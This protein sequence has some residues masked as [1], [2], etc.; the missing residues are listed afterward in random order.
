MLSVYPYRI[1]GIVS[2]ASHSIFSFV[3]IKAV[4]PC[5]TTSS[6]TFLIPFAFCQVPVGTHYG[7]CI[8]VEYEPVILAYAVRLER[9]TMNFVI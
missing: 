3:Y 8:F 2:T 5:S 6:A 4:L 7:V 1:R 9:I